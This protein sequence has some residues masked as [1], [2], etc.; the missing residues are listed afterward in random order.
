MNCEAIGSAGEIVSAVAV[1]VSLVYLAIQLRTNSR[2]LKASAAWDAE[3]IFAELNIKVAL[4]PEF[5]AIAMRYNSS[6]TSIEDF[7]EIERSQIW[8][9]LA[10]VIQLTQAQ[11]FMWK[12]GNLPDEIWQYRIAWIRNFIL[13]PVIRANWEQMKSQSVLS[14]NFVREIELEKGKKFYSQVIKAE[15]ELADK[16]GKGGT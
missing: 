4:D 1:V 11:Y 9:A 7:S 16:S 14:D 2:T 12:A 8:F 3:T 10:S 15:P 13:L 5:N 6:E